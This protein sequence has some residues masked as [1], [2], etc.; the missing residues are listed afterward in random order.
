MKMRFKII[1]FFLMTM[2]FMLEGRWDAHA[3]KKALRVGIIASLSGSQAEVGRDVRDGALLAIRHI[4]EKWKDKGA[5]IEAKVMDDTASPARAKD[6]PVLV[7]TP[8]VPMMAT[9]ASKSFCCP[10]SP[11]ASSMICREKS[12]NHQNTA[13]Q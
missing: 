2:V 9:T 7:P 8:P 3:G 11:M 1:V 4:N 6:L 13:R 10:C 5:R 12:I